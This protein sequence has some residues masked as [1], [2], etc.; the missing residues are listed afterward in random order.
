[1]D[2][3]MKNNRSA[4][5]LFDQKEKKILQVLVP[6]ERLKL[7]EKQFEKAKMEREKMK[8]KLTT[9]LIK[10]KEKVENEK[11]KCIQMNF[12]KQRV[13][14]SSIKSH[15]EIIKN[16]LR[17]TRLKVKINELNKEREE[18]QKVFEKK[19]KIKKQFKKMLNKVEAGN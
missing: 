17:I 15:Q 4:D 1:M 7:Y 13:A 14:F 12:E 2:K 18:V 8:E 9:R 11:E 6:E 10:G 5:N 19:E 16:N 3:S